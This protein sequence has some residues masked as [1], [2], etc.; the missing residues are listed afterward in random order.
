MNRGSLNRRVGVF[1]ALAA[2]QFI[3]RER[4]P[5]RKLVSPC[6]R[7]LCQGRNVAID[8]PV[9]FVNGGSPCT[10]SLVCEN[11]VWG[12]STRNQVQ[13]MPGM[14]EARSEEKER[15]REREREGGGEGEGEGE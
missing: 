9:S 4:E 15:E 2:E 1:L 6:Q 3:G 14:Q 11:A 10:F 13:Q 7:F 12:V 5:R 8:K